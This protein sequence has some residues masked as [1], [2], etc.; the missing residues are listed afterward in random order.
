MISFTLS[1]FNIESQL[2]CFELLFPDNLCSLRYIGI[3]QLTN[4][5]KTC[6]CLLIAPKSTNSCILKLKET[7]RSNKNTLLVSLKQS[8][9]MQKKPPKPRLK[10]WC[11][12]SQQ[13]DTFSIHLS[14]KPKFKKLR[15]PTTIHV[16]LHQISSLPQGIHAGC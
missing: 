12:V 13:L 2:D 15:I 1:G 8:L 7:V 9:D 6:A 5:G 4:S 14:P 16:A 11:N 3:L 10:P